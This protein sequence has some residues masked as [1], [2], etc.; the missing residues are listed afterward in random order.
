MHVFLC[1]G[2]LRVLQA[3]HLSLEELHTAWLSRLP[4]AKKR[5]RQK[6]P[7]VWVLICTNAPHPDVVQNLSNTK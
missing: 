4:T 5:W 3:D 2:S 7:A 1:S 6:K